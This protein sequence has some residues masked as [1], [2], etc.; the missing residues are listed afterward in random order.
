M[1]SMYE[2]SSIN[3]RGS[4][5]RFLY[6]LRAEPSS[7]NQRHYTEILRVDINMKKYLQF[8]PLLQRLLSLTEETSFRCKLH[9]RT[10]LE[11]CC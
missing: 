8:L 2:H 6:V 7:V 5:L 11:L 1:H 4:L 9:Q 10:S 3:Q